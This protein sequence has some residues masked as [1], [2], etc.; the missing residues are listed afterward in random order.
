MPSL[1]ELLTNNNVYG[2]RVRQPYSSENTFFKRNPSVAGMAAEDNQ[3][4]LN[5]YSPLTNER[6]AAVARNEA[7][8]LYMRENDL[9]PQFQVTPEQTKYFAGMEYGKPENAKYMRQTILSRIFSGDPTANATPEQVD[10]AKRIA[11]G[12]RSRA[13]TY[14]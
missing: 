1:S 14:E 2:Y 4:T 13:P 6:K 12:L 8:R 5:P 9:D 10:I 11:Q 3:I 7:L